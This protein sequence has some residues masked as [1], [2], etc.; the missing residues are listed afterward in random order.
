[1]AGVRS[2]RAA[3]RAGGGAGVRGS[4]RAR[5]RARAPSSSGSPTPRVHADQA[6][7][8]PAQP[9]VR[10]AHASRRAPTPSW[11]RSSDDLGAAA[12]ARRRGPGVRRGGRGARRPA[13]RR[14]RSG[15][16]T[17][18][19]RGT[20]SDGK[21]ALLEIKSGEGGEESA[22]FAG[23]LLRMY[24]RYAEQRGWRTEQLDATE[25]D[26]GG[27]K[28]VTVAVKAKGTP[29]PGEAPYAL[30]K[31][32]G[33]VHRVQRVP[34]TESQGRVHTSAAGVLVMPE[35][36]PVD[37]TDRREGPAHRRVPLLRPGRPERQHHR[38][39][40]AHHP[41]AD[42]PRGQL[43]E[44][45]VPAAEQGAGAAH[46][47]RRG[48]CRPPRRPRRPRPPTPAARRSAPSTGPSG[49]APTTSPR[50]GSPTTAPATSPTTS[51]RCSTATSA[52][53]IESCVAGGPRGP[54]R[55]RSSSE[56]AADRRRRCLRAAAR[57]GCARP[58]SPSP[59]FDAAEL[60]AHVLG[61]TRGRWLLPPVD[62]PGDAE[63]YAALGR[64]SRGPGARCSTSPAPPG[65]ATSSSRSGPG[66]SC[67]RP[68]DRGARRAGRS[69]GPAS[70]VRAGA[71][72]R[73][74]PLHRLGRHRAGGRHRGARGQGA[75]RRARRGGTRLGRAQPGRL[76]GST[77]GSA[78]WPTPSPTS[79]ARSTWW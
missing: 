6:L 8:K 17:C 45:E 39:G 64:P 55:R 57:R 78:T 66:S 74:R 40:G 59:E 37:V 71:A 46:P 23:D 1:M 24:T 61:T 19:S 53:V 4:R 58:A 18:S 30:L 13:G 20:P 5:R 36:E 7:A 47:A 50:T 76:A 11:H 29:E 12:R 75:R 2:V 15:C 67:P 42:R 77:C 62:G 51:T 70:V 9:A 34:V 43:P 28:S 3:V 38:L 49:S 54:A 68:G 65:S 21:D 44:R 22:L 73:G 25:S 27:Y 60:L 52:P 56:P 33:G 16:A 35:A 79:T 32:E 14:P 48:C 10:R 26:L 69:T 31:F 63:A 41:P 72:G